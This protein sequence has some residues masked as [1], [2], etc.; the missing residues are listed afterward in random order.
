MKRTLF[1]VLIFSLL[2]A[3]SCDSSSSGG[4][5]E[6]TPE[7]R[8]QLDVNTMVSLGNSLTAGFQSGGWSFELVQKSWTSLIAKQIYGADATGVGDNNDRYVVT[9][10]AGNGFPEPL[11]V[12]QYLQVG[13]FANGSPKLIFTVA[14]GETNIDNLLSLN[15]DYEAPFNNLGVPGATTLDI[16]REINGFTAVGGTPPFGNPFFRLVLRDRGSELDEAIAIK[17][18][19]IT[20]WSGNNELLA[21]ATSGGITPIFPFENNSETT[22]FRDLYTDLI[23]QLKDTG[24]Q[25]VTA[26]I[27]DVTQIPVAASVGM[28][29]ADGFRAYVADVN[30]DR[31][32]S[33]TLR[34]WGLDDGN[35]ARELSSDERVLLDW[36]RQQQQDPG[37]GLSAD[38]PLLDGLWLSA[39]EIEILRGSIVQYNDFIRS[40]NNDP[41]ILVVDIFTEFNRIADNGG[42]FTV[43]DETISVTFALPFGGMFSL[44]GVHPADA[45]HAVLANFF[46]DAI[47]QE[48]DAGISRVPVAPLLPE[49][50]PIIN[51]TAAEAVSTPKNTAFQQMKTIL[52][53]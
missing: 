41:Q 49:A 30:G 13:T 1:S 16:I 6:P 42:I 46:I 53:W 27:P 43:E 40:F 34:F 3:N 4:D 2:L 14:G 35:A 19:F 25:I 38:K 17:P 10:I 37:L 29:T 39:Q 11:R 21:N 45:G 36:Q 48:W 47:N 51:A 31:V 15:A 26:T 44:D 32:F 52:G 22:G 20:V 8:G 28:N 12:D 9:Q 5:D 50:L 7:L 33:D 24:A 23:N 18:S